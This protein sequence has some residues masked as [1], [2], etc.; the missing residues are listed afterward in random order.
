MISIG[1]KDGHQLVVAYERSRFSQCITTTRQDRGIGWMVSRDLAQH[2]PH[3]TAQQRRD[4]L[5]LV[6]H[7]REVRLGT[8][9]DLVRADRGV[10]ASATSRRSAPVSAAGLRRLGPALLEPR[11]VLIQRTPTLRSAH[12]R[13]RGPAP[14]R[15]S[16]PSPARC[17]Q[18][19]HPSELTSAVSTCTPGMSRSVCRAAAS[20]QY[21]G[22]PAADRTLPIGQGSELARQQ[23]IDAGSRVGEERVPLVLSSRSMANCCS[24]SRARRISRSTR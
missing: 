16:A 19:R 13:S 11:A 2:R 5:N 12:P 20:L 17:Q 4:L 23:E 24:V 8:T 9:Q 10:S 6:G 1:S 3:R 22:E 18:S 7:P 14:A 15:Q 21:G